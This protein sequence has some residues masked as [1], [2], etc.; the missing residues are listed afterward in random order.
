MKGQKDLIA[1]AKILLESYPAI[2]FHLIIVGYG[3]QF[4]DLTQMAKD[5][6]VKGNVTFTGKRTDLHNFYSMADWFIMPCHDESMGLVI[7]EALAYGVPVIAYNSGSIGEVISDESMGFLVEKKPEKIVD[8]IVSQPVEKIKQQ[9]KAK[10]L[11]GFSAKRMVDDY[12]RV[13][14]LFET[15]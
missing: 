12:L 7:Y 15:Q 3:P 13:Y 2:K 14:G 5:Y 1:M 11:S 4:A 8:V 6:E 10:D 9:L